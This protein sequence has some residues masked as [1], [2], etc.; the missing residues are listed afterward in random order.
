[1]QIEIVNRNW[2]NHC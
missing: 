1:L 2:N